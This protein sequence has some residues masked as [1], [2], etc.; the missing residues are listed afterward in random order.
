MIIICTVILCRYVFRLD[1]YEFIHNTERRTVA[2]PIA[3]NVKSW[4]LCIPACCWDLQYS[5]RREIGVHCRDH[6]TS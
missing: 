6:P 1:V 3:C 4:T 5:Q 2:H